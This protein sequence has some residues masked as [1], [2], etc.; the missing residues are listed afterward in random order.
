MT[1]FTKKY[2]SVRNML[3]IYKGIGKR[4][5]KE[6][7]KKFIRKLLKK[8]ESRKFRTLVLNN[9]IMYNCITNYDGLINLLFK[10]P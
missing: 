5:Y 3:K 7:R 10:D 8:V 1:K 6:I 4:V 9:T 2:D